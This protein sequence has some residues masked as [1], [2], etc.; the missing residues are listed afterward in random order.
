MT[1]PFPVGT[2]VVNIAAC[3]I[4]GFL[5]GLADQRQMIGPQ[6]RLFWTVGFCG[7]FSTFSAFSQESYRLMQSGMTTAMLLYIL[8][9]VLLCL[10]ATFAG[11]WA[12][13]AM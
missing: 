1:N 9:S 11:M 3:L 10:A 4:L 13:R 12:A 2:L 7:G 6:M 8:L 5:T